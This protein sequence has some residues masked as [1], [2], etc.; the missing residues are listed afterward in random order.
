MLPLL[1][2]LVMDGHVLAGGAVVELGAQQLSN[3]VLH[4]RAEL[5]RLADALGIEA[6]CELPGPVATGELL[7]GIEPLNIA[8]P[9]AEQLWRWLGFEYSCIDIDG[10]PGAIPLDLNYDRV[11]MDARGRYSL[12]TN[13]GTTE[14]IAN[15]LN[16]FKVVHDLA[17][18]GGVM[19]H[20]VP[21]QGLFNHGLVNYNPKFFWMLARSNGYRV[22]HA[23]FWTAPQGEALPRNVLDHVASYV[24][25]AGNRLA[26]YRAADCML[27]F[28]LKK[29][30]P[31][32][33]VAPLDVMTGTRTDNAAIEERYWTVFTPDAFDGLRPGRRLSRSYRWLERRLMSAFAIRSQA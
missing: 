3:S 5:K 20:H 23:D 13:F 17:G 11:P 8:A 30:Y 26:D 18:P 19:I 21:A 16:A 29:V 32:E 6:R 1:R 7:E 15:Q 2:Q 31:M 9:R 4:A 25:D 14:H 24:P 27:L 12:V 22:L 28:V 33:F 10:S